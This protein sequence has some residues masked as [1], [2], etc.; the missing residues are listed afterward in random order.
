MLP[1]NQMQQPTSA[2]VAL[3]PERQDAGMKDRPWTSGCKQDESRSAPGDGSRTRSGRAMRMA[4]RPWMSTRRSGSRNGNPSG[5]HWRPG[6]T[7]AAVSPTLLTFR[8]IPFGMRFPPAF[9]QEQLP[10]CG[11]SEMLR[12]E[13]GIP[14]FSVADSMRTSR[15]TRSC[16]CC[17]TFARSSSLPRNPTRSR[18]RRV[19][20]TATARAE[21]E[22]RARPKRPIRWADRLVLIRNAHAG[23]LER[24][25]T[26]TV[27][28]P[29]R[30]SSPT[31]SSSAP[32]PTGPRTT[33]APTN[34]AHPGRESAP[35]RRSRCRA[36]R[37][38]ATSP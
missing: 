38:A 3:A 25:E 5:V 21:R 34:A 36:E 37:L 29:S 31:N 33:A 22:P 28:A 8:R 17:S 27:P 9:E 13:S 15:G 23:T 12:C 11:A 1:P 2:P 20:I 26:P 19:A 24:A 14:T 18:G 30:L 32:V 6:A 7:Q 4:G 35:A 10:I 16:N